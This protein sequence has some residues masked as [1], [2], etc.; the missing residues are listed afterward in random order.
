VFEREDAFYSAHQAEFHEKYY[1]KWLVIIGE[2][3]WKT[4]R[5]G[6]QSA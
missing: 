1:D 6:Y 4:D 3:L 2:S 5:Q